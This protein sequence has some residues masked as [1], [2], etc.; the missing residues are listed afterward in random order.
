[1]PVP[2][3][4]HIL[5]CLAFATGCSAT[6]ENEILT[7]RDAP[8]GRHSAVLF[9]RDCGATTSYSTQ[10]SILAPGERPN[11]TG[12][13]LIADDYH[14]SAATGDWGGPWAEVEWM[15][16]YHLLVRY[17]VRSRTF[18]R[19]ASVSGVRITYQMTNR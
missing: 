6:C 1:M 19:Q 4:L 9:R 7:E 3:T 10:L 15:A 18:E 13:V 8:D 17:A 5:T 14:G 2:R 12:N 16:P 11:R